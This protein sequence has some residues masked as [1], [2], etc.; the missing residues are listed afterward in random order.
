MTVDALDPAAA[1]A[2]PAPPPLRRNRDFVLLWTGTALSS[3]G[4]QVS[5]FAYPL[6]VLWSGGSVRSA[7]LVGAAA[8][9]PQLVLS[10]FAGVLVDRFDRKRLMLGCNL[11]R[12]AALA[13]LVA[14]LLAGKVLLPVLLAVAFVEASLGVVHKLA[15]HAAVR[16]VVHPDHLDQAI[17]QNEARVQATGLLGQP[18]AGALSAVAFWVPLLFTAVSQL[19]SFTTL[20]AIRKGFQAERTDPAERGKVLAEIA[21]GVRWLW[22]HHQL[23]AAAGVIAVSNLLFEVLTLGMLTVL[24]HDGVSPAVVGLVMGAAGV[25][26]VIGALSTS[27][28]LER[29][30]LPVIVLGANLIW[31]VLF[32]LTVLLHNPLLFALVI[33]PMALIGAA[34]TIAV[35][36]FQV[37]VTPDEMQGRIASVVSII[38]FGTLP[39]GALVGGFALQSF[40]F[41]PTV[42]ACSG[43][44]ALLALSAVLSPSLRRI[45]TEPAPTPTGK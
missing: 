37:R 43:V 22:N 10:L 44:M 38:A 34:W 39:L 25:G 21:A 9:L 29:L 28:W 24:R 8:A 11:G 4:S 17:S 6:I 33:T 15:E 18:L 3:L 1:F 20:S 2:P 40:G 32:P 13:V 27:W 19:V 45:G 31:A 5:A 7:G 14:T 16:N 23:R 26:G 35:V 12:F 30:S 36:S 42:L 41:R